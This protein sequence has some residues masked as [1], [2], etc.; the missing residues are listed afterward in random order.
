[1]RAAL[2]RTNAIAW[3]DQRTAQQGRPGSLTAIGIGWASAAAAPLAGYK[4]TASEGGL[5]VPMIVAW[6]ANPAVAKGVVTTGFGH[7]TDIVPTL[8]DLA[9]VAPVAVPG[10]APLTGHSLVPMLG[11]GDIGVRAA[12]EP[13]GYELAGNAVLWRG[14]LKLVRNLP[15]YGDG[16]WHLFDIVADPGETADLA[17]ARPADFAALQ[18]DYAAWAQAN[19]VLAMPPGYS[20][21]QQIMDNAWNDLFWPRTRPVLAWAGGLLALGIGAGWLWRRRAARWNYPQN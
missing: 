9:R 19:G 13:L 14:N 5:R 16:R 21:P 3:Y 18:A 2:P 12:D 17:A 10:K 6:P 15:P 1:M 8:L 20:A 7:V 4:F 11:G